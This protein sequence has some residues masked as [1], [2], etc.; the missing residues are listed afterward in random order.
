MTDRGYY[1]FYTPGEYESYQQ[2]PPYNYGQTSEARLEET[3]IKFMEMQQQQNEQMQQMQDQ[4]QQYLKNSLA[5]AKNLENQLVQLTKQLAN[6]NYQGGTFQTNTQTTPDEK[7]NNPMKNEE[8]GESVKDVENNE[9]E[10]MC[11]GCGVE[12]IVEEIETPKEV[13]LPQESPCIENISTV[14]NE[15]V[16]MAAEEI[17]GLLDKEIS[18]EQKREMENQALIDR[19]IDE[20]CAL[21]NKK[22][23]G[24]WTPQ[25]LYLKFMEFLPNRRKKTD[26]VLSVSFWPP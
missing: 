26:D 6:N 10:R 22:E 5:R 24:I 3:M 15:E 11:D 14:D 12:K 16:M 13:E 18:I 4:H 23:L 17:E 20:I 7:D 21:F 8:S 19:V 25:H 9:E 1:N 2:F